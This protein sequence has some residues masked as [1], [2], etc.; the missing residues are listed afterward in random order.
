M[1]AV[2]KSSAFGLGFW[3]AKSPCFSDPAA[4]F[5]YHVLLQIGPWSFNFHCGRS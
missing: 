2:K 1:M 3:F 5:K 4:V